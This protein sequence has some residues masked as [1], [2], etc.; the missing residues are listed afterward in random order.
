MHVPQIARGYMKP[1]Q[2]RRPGLNNT[3]SRSLWNNQVPLVNRERI[4]G[5]D[6]EMYVQQKVSAYIKPPL[7]NKSEQSNLLLRVLIL[8]HSHI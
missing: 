3:I 5:C 7:N 6:T 2:G 4:L 8:V 1:P